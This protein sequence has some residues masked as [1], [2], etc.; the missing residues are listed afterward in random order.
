MLHGFLFVPLRNIFF[1]L[2]AV[3]GGGGRIIKT[4]GAFEPH[5]IA[6]VLQGAG[7][8]ANSRHFQR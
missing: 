3:L 1:H 5:H 6:G 7:G 4:G 2:E 8:D